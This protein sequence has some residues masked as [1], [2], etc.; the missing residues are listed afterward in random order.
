LRVEGCD[1][2]RTSGA[3]HAISAAELAEG[4]LAPEEWETLPAMA[5]SIQSLCAG[6]VGVTGRACVCASGSVSEEQT[7]VRN[8]RR[9]CGGLV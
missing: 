3:I 9:A 1:S 6:V 2:G 4:I 7:R 8:V 5:C